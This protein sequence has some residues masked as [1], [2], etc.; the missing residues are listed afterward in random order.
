MPMLYLLVCNELCRVRQ[1][2]EQVEEKIAKSRKKN[3]IQFL[4]V[5]QA[6]VRG[7]Q[8]EYDTALVAGLKHYQGLS[9]SYLDATIAKYICRE[10]TSI[11]LMAERLGKKCP[12]LPEELGACL[13]TKAS[14]G[15]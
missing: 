15:C 3:P 14:V 5:F 9:E 4:K 2:S 13:M 11:N 6:A 12:D 1:P 8:A 7:N 10:L